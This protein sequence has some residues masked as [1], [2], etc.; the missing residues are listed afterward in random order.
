MERELRHEGGGCPSRIWATTHPDEEA[1][2]EDD[3]GELRAA[4]EVAREVGLLVQ[5][6]AG[7]RRGG[8]Y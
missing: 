8:Y 7:H 5:A 6:F 2:G 4:L 1:A 3:L